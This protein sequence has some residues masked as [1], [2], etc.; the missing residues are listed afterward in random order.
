MLQTNHQVKSSTLHIF[1]FFLTAFLSISSGIIA[2]SDGIIIFKVTQAIIERGEISLS[3]DSVPPGAG[4][5]RYS[6]YGIAQSVL[7]IPLYLLG[8]LVSSTIPEQFNDLIL[9]GSVSLTNAI[10]GA[11][12]CL[13]LV[14][15]A[16]QLSYSQPVSLQL[17][18]SF[19]FSTFF[20]VYATKSFLTH[21][22]ETLCLVGTVC[23]FVAFSRDRDP[24][25]LIY[26]GLF[27]GG[28]ILTKWTFAVNLPVFILYLLAA[29]SNGRRARD[30]SLFF[31]PVGAS[32]ALALWYN[33]ARFGSILETGYGVATGTAT[34]LF[35]TSLPVGVYGLLFSPGR[36][37]FLYA[38]IAVLGFASAKAF[39]KTHRREM[40]MLIGLFAANML[41]IAKYRYWGGGFTW[42]PRLLT[43]VLPCLVL[44]IGALLQHGST[45]VRRGFLVLSLAGLLV[46][47]GGVSIFYGTY[48]RAIGGYP[49][50]P[51]VTDPLFL[52]KS[53]F[54]PS[55]SPAWRQFKMAWQ[56]WGIF[57]DGQKP[58]FRILPG[59]ERIPL[60]EA[61]RDNLLQ[62]L[63]LWFAYAYYA[64]VPWGLC[65][66]GIASL[67]GAT[68]AMGW[69][70]YRSCGV[71]EQ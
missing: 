38:P 56:N 26:A 27:S 30:L 5:K 3:D 13:L 71:E 59:S 43:L 57:L 33:Y 68:A 40:W 18:M 31:A 4:E 65:L 58:T 66:L 70:L 60:S 61:D 44:P 54:L 8:K 63:D 34:S 52:Y 6:Q 49:Y 14:R 69:H 45:W 10:V 7:A 17:A 47:F 11:F 21:P 22:L 1:V 39:A 62:T 41:L 37:L 36:S 2:S 42:G 12:A 19:A 29:S 16:Q 53:N 55:Y 35:S 32:L 67:L 23:F 25:V 9:K 51:G 15:T 28:G 48:N 46:Q 20:V 50:R 64:G 24:R